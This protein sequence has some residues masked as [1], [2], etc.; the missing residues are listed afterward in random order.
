MTTTFED[1]F[2]NDVDE[3]KASDVETP[4][5]NAVAEKRTARIVAIRTTSLSTP[6]G[7]RGADE[8][9]KGR[10]HCATPASVRP[11][12]RRNSPHSR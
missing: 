11:S 3:Q 8:T 4:T 7:A 9:V 10:S 12:V 6:V 1:R 5:E 2:R